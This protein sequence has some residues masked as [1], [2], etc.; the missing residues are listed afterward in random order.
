MLPKTADSDAS[1]TS[2]AGAEKHGGRRPEHSAHGGKDAQKCRLLLGSIYHCLA[3]PKSQIAKALN[4]DG[5]QDKLG[6]ARTLTDC[7]LLSNYSHFVQ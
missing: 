6:F 2:V 7:T 4:I 3:D 1:A 5:L